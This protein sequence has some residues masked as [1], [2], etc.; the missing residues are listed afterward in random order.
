MKNLLL[1]LRVSCLSLILG[2][3]SLGLLFA[4]VQPNDAKAQ[5]T[6]YTGVVYVYESENDTLSVKATGGMLYFYKLN[7]SGNMILKATATIN[8]NGEYVASVPGTSDLY[9]VAFPNDEQDNFVASYYPGWLDFESADPMDDA[10]H[11]GDTVDTDW[12]AVGKEI[13]ERPAPNAI[14]NTIHGNINTTN[15]LSDDLIPMVYLMS[16][17]TVLTSA[18]VLKDGSYTMEFVGSGIYEVFTSIPGYASQSKYIT[19]VENTK[20]NFNID[21]NLDVYRGEIETTPVNTVVNNFSLKQNYPNPF[22]PTTN[23]NFTLNVEGKVKLTVYNSIGKEVR[24]LINDLMEP[25]SYD[26]PFNASNLASGVYYYTL[27]VGNHVETKRMNL[28]K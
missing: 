6:V 10:A 12:G 28:I 22:N 18:P 20:G 5:Q 8:E 21:F 13:V 9:V 23:I 19:A 16:G 11:S 15:N 17:N 26:V 24:S 2:I 27:Q 4:L 25:G 7:N 1:K 14:I 3:F